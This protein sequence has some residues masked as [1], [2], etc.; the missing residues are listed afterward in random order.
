MSLPLLP[1]SSPELRQCDPLPEME[2][3]RGQATQK[4]QPRV[5]SD[6]DSS[7][8]VGESHSGDDAPVRKRRKQD[9][10]KRFPSGYGGLRC[11]VHVHVHVS[12]V[13]LY[14]W[15]FACKEPGCERS[16][17]RKHDLMRHR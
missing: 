15:Q 14:K 9:M 6:A 7:Y 5:D 13:H 16:F 8:L 1:L 2:A 3:K 11:G 10:T 17:S 4:K 12:N